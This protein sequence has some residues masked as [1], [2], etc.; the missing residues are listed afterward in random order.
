MQLIADRFVVDDRGHAIDL[1]TNQPVW[2]LS[3]TA[4]GPTEQ[5]QWAERCAWFSR[6]TQPAVAPLLD[7]GGVGETQRFEAWAVQPGWRGS[8]AAAEQALSR[9]ARFLVA[10]ARVPITR[11]IALVGCRG[12]RPVVVPD[13]AAGIALDELAD[14]GTRDTCSAGSRGAALADERE[15]LG[16]VSAT[17]RRLRPVA[18]VLA[19]QVSSRVVSLAL[20]AAE[21][22]GVRHAVRRTRPGGAPCRMHSRFDIAVYRAVAPGTARSHAAAS[23]GRGYRRRMAKHG[24]RNPRRPETAHRALRGIARGGQGAHRLPRAAAIRHVDCLSVSAGS[25]QTP[26]PSRE[27][28]REAFTRTAHALRAPAVRQRSRDI[29]GRGLAPWVGSGRGCTSRRTAWQRRGVPTR[30]LRVPCP[31]RRSEQRGGVLTMVVNV[32]GRGRRPAKLRGF[33]AGSIRPVDCWRADVTD[34][35]NG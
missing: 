17:E 9:A 10:N 33:A 24:G 28:R 21:G 35:A 6:V 11:N 14:P 23:R 7:Y 2:L 31:N 30:R 32:H 5:T 22:G 4:G 20:W 13:A 16:V 19:G 26:H 29:G 34:R 12:G 18:D 27:Y 25:C 3:S 8:G 15:L 1:A